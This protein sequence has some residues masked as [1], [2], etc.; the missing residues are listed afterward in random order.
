M[1]WTHRTTAAAF[2]SWHAHASEQKEQNAVCTR[3]LR[4]ML[5]RKL[6]IAF[7][8]WRAHSLAQKR[9]ETVCGRIVAKMLNGKLAVAFVTWREHASEQRHM[10]DVCSRMLLKMMHRSLAIAW[11]R[12]LD[13][14]LELARLLRMSNR[15]LARWCHVCL[16]SSWERWFIELCRSRKIRVFV[17]KFLNKALA[18]AWNTWCEEYSRCDNRSM[19]DSS[20]SVLP[21]RVPK[22]TTLLEKEGGVDVSLV[23]GL[24]FLQ[25]GQEGM[26]ELERRIS[27]DL[28]LAS[29]WERQQSAPLTRMVYIERCKDL[30][31][32]MAFSFPSKR[33]QSGHCMA[34][35]EAAG[36]KAKMQGG[37]NTRQAQQMSLHRGWNSDTFSATWLAGTGHCMAIDKVAGRVSFSTYPPPSDEQSLPSAKIKV[38][39]AGSPAALNGLKEG[40]RIYEIDDKPVS[41]SMD[42]E[43]VA[44]MLRGAPGTVVRLRVGPPEDNRA[45]G[46]PPECFVIKNLIPLVVRTD[47][48]ARK[49]KST[50]RLRRRASAGDVFERGNLPGERSSIHVDV[51][52]LPL[53]SNKSLHPGSVA[54]DLASQAHDPASRL[55]TGSLTQHLQS[56]TVT[57][58]P[59]QHPSAAAKSTARAL[60]LHSL[61]PDSNSD[62]PQQK[63][64]SV[65]CSDTECV[66]LSFTRQL[67]ED[68]KPLMFSMVS[69]DIP[70]ADRH[71]LLFSQEY[72]SIFENNIK[73][74]VCATLNVP[75]AC[76]TV[77]VVAPWP[78]HENFLLASEHVI[79]VKVILSDVVDRFGDVTMKAKDMMVPL[80]EAAI[81]PGSKFATDDLPTAVHSQT[82]GFMS[83]PV[84]EFLENLAR[85]VLQLQVNH[86]SSSRD[87]PPLQQLAVS[88]TC[89]SCLKSSEDKGIIDARKGTHSPRIAVNQACLII[90]D[91]P[92]NS[93]IDNASLKSPRAFSPGAGRTHRHQDSATGILHG[94]LTIGQYAGALLGGMDLRS[95]PEAPGGGSSGD[96]HP[97]KRMDEDTAEGLP[98]GEAESVSIDTV[99]GGLYVYTENGTELRCLSMCGQLFDSHSL[100]VLASPRNAHDEGNSTHA[101]LPPTTM[102][103][104]SSTQISGI[105]ESFRFAFANF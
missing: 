61:K 15:V 84:A 13:H 37:K 56:L 31:L 19:E 7:D 97:V 94:F 17:F 2:E 27:E 85:Q 28:A 75:S 81:D 23:L 58:L 77:F 52:V 32:G 36:D 59:G 102:G 57:S 11:K 86:N 49:P 29:G 1:H 68:K 105:D 4:H 80:A 87:D 42:S 43:E 70:V 47:R 45:Q 101:L 25:A 104:A 40:E 38:V 10:Q 12:W 26:K 44:A 33:K 55:R 51:T 63:L 34:L 3:V 62:V 50:D 90:D 65:V 79:T 71:T 24:D 35:D 67:G 92:D 60:D 30:G 53:A 6:S 39:T 41:A 20:Y 66:G 88:Q 93:F 16:A 83:F 82:L 21:F 100:E 72:R 5:K 48:L 96:A 73:V 74:Q 69:L 54:G 98:P 95:L 78:D 76:V 91:I 8:S 64:V 103:R 46:L 99:G 9:M 18:R 89:S 22:I 14:Y